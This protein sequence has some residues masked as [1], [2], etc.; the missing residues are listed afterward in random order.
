MP[1]KGPKRTAKKPP[2]KLNQDTQS[3]LPFPKARKL[4]WTAISAT[5]T[6][7]A[8][9]I[10]WPRV[11]VSVSTPLDPQNVLSAPFVISNTGNITLNHANVVI[12]A[13]YLNIPTSKNP[14]IVRLHDEDKGTGKQGLAFA[15]PSWQDHK[16]EIDKS[17]TI[18]PESQIIGRTSEADIV[19]LVSYNPWLL[20]FRKENRF[21]FVARKDGSGNVYWRSWPLNEKAPSN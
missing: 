14:L 9:W 17:I 1:N 18:N 8:F 20:P 21:R 4:A 12:I 15:D 5:A 13:S 6:L 10:W 11:N 3:R 16:I 2:K 19:L 7:L